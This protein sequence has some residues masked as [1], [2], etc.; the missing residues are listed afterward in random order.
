MNTTASAPPLPSLRWSAKSLASLAASRQLRLAAVY[1]SVSGIAF[2]AYFASGIATAALVYV[3]VSALPVIALLVGP[4][5]YRPRDP[6]PWLWLAAGQAAFFVGDVIWFSDKLPGNRGFPSTADIAYLVAYPLL[7]IGLAQVI[8]ARRPTMRLVPLID[9]LVIGMVG[10]LFVWLAYVDRIVDDLAVAAVDKLVMLAYPVG[11]VLLLAMAAYLLLAGRSRWLAAPAMLV[12][13]F[14]L[15]L[16][17][18]TSYAGVAADLPLAASLPDAAWLGSCVLIG[19]AALLPSMSSLT[20]PYPDAGA[21]HRLWPKLFMAIVLLAVPVF[22]VLQQLLFNDIDTAVIV[23]AQVVMVAALLVR[24][25]EAGNAQAASA[26]RY[27]LANSE[28]RRL[29]AAIEQTSDAVIIADAKAN[30]EYV[31]PAF[32][33]IT[34]YRRTEAIGRNPRFLQGG[35]QAPSFYT[36]MWNTLSAG[37]PWVADFVNRRKDGS[38]YTAEAVISS[39]RDAS[40]AVTGY[41]GVSRDVTDERR[42]EEHA[43]QLARERALIS[44]T[45]RNID[46]RNEPEEIAHAVCSQVARLPDIATA[47]LVFFERDGR[48]IPYGLVLASG[49]SAPCKGLPKRRVDQVR[50]RAFNGP[51]VEAWEDRPWHPY[52][53]LLNGLGV[54]AVAYAPVRDGGEMIGYL[55]ISSAVPRAGERLT[56]VL[57]ALVEFA[58]ISGTLLATKVAERTRASGEREHIEKVIEQQALF[59]VYQ[60]LFD[61]VTRRIVGYEALTRFY[62]GVAPDVRLA[63][64]HAVGLGERLELL[65]IEIALERAGNLPHEMWFNVNASPAVVMDGGEL[66]RLA[67]ASDRQLVLEVTEHTEITDYPAFRRAIRELGPRVRLAVDDAGAGFASLRHIIELRPAFVKLD[68]QVIAGIDHDEARQAMVAGLRHFALNTGCWLIAEGVETQAELDTLRE[69]E[70]RYVQGYLLGQ[71]VPAHRLTDDVARWSGRQAL[72]GRA[73]Q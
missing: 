69:L 68:R 7:G 56:Q 49:E 24:V 59:P 27:E 2:V 30:I 16:L 51:W 10:A 19:L 63:E 4:L 71:P 58:D 34:G 13:A 28:L 31:N 14:V 35:N 37:S 6:L 44:E 54:Q 25:R 17:G 43:A 73:N 53:K 8:R 40:G 5:L 21:T 52:N 66:Q 46:T 26:E 22:A 55:L 39:I 60:P 32:E 12:G 47:A 9:A 23:G 38:I 20:E 41:V 50:Q 33:L 11:D 64:A 72:L 48:A 29:G 1:L 70:V 45:I 42:L 61:V 36:A 18:D 57:P 15:Q 67:Y 3:V 65:A 62:D